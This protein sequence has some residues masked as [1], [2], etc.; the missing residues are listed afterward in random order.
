MRLLRADPRRQRLLLERL[1]YVDLS[2]LW[3]VE[4]CEIVAGFYPRLHKPAPPS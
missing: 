3:D 2:E 1:S 4:A